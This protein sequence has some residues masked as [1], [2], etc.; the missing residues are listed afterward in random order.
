MGRATGSLALAGFALNALWD[1]SASVL[2]RRSR[3]GRTDPAAAEHLERRAQ[4]WIIVAIL[5]I[6]SYI[7]IQAVS[8]LLAGSHAEASP[9]G[10]ATVHSRTLGQGTMPSLGD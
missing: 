3:R 10:L 1:S 2:V 5:L 9:F 6:A 8:A 7:A 4:T